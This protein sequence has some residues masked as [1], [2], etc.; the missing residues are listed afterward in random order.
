[1]LLRVSWFDV[2]LGCFACGGYLETLG[3]VVCGVLALVFV[4]GLLVCLN[5]L[6]DVVCVRLSF[7]LF[8]LVQ[9]CCRGGVL[10]VFLYVLFLL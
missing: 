6:V 7:Y 9:T 1:M 5:F 8:I 2:V 4:F 10:G 3:L